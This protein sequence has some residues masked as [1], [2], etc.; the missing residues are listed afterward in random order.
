MRCIDHI[1]WLASKIG[2]EIFIGLRKKLSHIFL[3]DEPDMRGGDH[4]RQV[5]KWIVL[6]QR[7]TRKDI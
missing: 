2:D 5:S 7:L 4:V 6:W 1:D 3:R